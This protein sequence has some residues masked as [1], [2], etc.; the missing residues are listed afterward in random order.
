MLKPAWLNK[1]IDIR[2]NRSMK[3]L[4]RTFGL[5]TVCEES[6]C[7]N[8]SECFGRGAATFLV[9]GDICTRACSFCNVRKGSPLAS[10]PQE[11]QRLAEA[12]KKLSVKYLVITSPT[13]D[14]LKDGG[15]G[16]LAAP[17]VGE[18]AEHG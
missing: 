4:L 18:D 11:P 5:S 10:D 8:Q 7:P 6:S 15:A 1:K 3:E 9:L 14:D 12:V 17:A 13:R 16:H 2:Q